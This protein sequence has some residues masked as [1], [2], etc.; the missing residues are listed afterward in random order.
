MTSDNTLVRKDSILTGDKV[1]DDA[2]DPSIEWDI[3]P[4]DTFSFLGSHKAGG[5]V[6]PDPE[7]PTVISIAEAR[8][9][10][11]GSAT[12]KGIVTATLKNTI[13][14]QDDTAAIA[15]RPTSLDA[16][17][18]DEITVSGSLQDY[19]GLLQLDSA[20]LI[21]KRKVKANLHRL[22]WQGKC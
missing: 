1:H 22:N 17:L 18:G 3:H 7:Q 6:D 9:Q 19:R 21:E 16:Q 4:K 8:A 15:V 11:T 2:F 14:I 13:H 12:V 10:G 20:T 5:N